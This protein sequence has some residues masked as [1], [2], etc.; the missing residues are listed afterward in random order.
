M[1]V[2]EVVRLA[3]PYAVLR[4]RSSTGPAE[5]YESS[6]PEKRRWGAAEERM[7]LSALPDFPSKPPVE[8]TI[9]PDDRVTL[10]WGSASTTQCVRGGSEGQPGRER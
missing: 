9:T 8:D 7:M 1:V 4:I 5:L 10:R 2:G 6:V 3:T